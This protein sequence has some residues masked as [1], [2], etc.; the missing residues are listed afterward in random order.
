MAAKRDLDAIR[1]N[2]VIVVWSCRHGS[3]LMRASKQPSRPLMMFDVTISSDYGREAHLTSTC[4]KP[5]SI[6][7]ISVCQTVKARGLHDVVES[8][9]RSL[10]RPIRPA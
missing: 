8:F 1:P 9:R 7:S 5:D 10:G 3:F 6:G 4:Q 2:R